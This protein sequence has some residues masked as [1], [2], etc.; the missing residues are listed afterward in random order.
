MDCHA[1]Y[2]SSDEEF[3]F[4]MLLNEEEEHVLKTI[5]QPRSC[6]IKRTRSNCFWN[7]VYPE[8]DVVTYKHYYRKSKESMNKLTDIVNIEL[9]DYADNWDKLHKI[10]ENDLGLLLNS[11]SNRRRR[12]GQMGWRNAVK[13]IRTS[14]Q[15]RN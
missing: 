6:Y 14:Q 4:K 1:I 13:I 15:N 7:N 8:L 11:P 12:V 3:V 9:E 10:I 5:R 2:D